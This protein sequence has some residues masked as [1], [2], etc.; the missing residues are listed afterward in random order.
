MLISRPFSGL[1][2]YCILAIVGIVMAF[3][4]TFPSSNLLGELLVLYSK[5]TGL[6]NFIQSYL[7]D[8]HVE[9]VQETMLEKPVRKNNAGRTSLERIYWKL[10]RLWD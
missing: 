2:M 3:T 9:F 6:V 5:V 10:L 1:S 4:L 8:I 7:K